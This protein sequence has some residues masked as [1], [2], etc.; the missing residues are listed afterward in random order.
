MQIGVRG[1]GFV[2]LCKRTAG[3]FIAAAV[4]LGCFGVATAQTAL[5]D[6]V[7]KRPRPE[8]DPIGIPLGPEGGFLLFPK[9]EIAGVYID[10]LFK[11]ETGET[12]DEIGLFT[13]SLNIRSDWDLHAL[14]FSA[15]STYAKHRDNSAEDWW[16]YTGK[17]AGRLDVTETGVVS[18]AVSFSRKHENRSSPD[19]PSRTKPTRYTIGE[20]NVI[21]TYNPDVL[22]FR[23]ELSAKQ[24]DYRDNGSVNNDDR[25]R[26]Q[27]GVRGRVGYE[28]VPGSMAFVEVG[29]NKREF[30]E[31]IDIAADGSTKETYDRSSEGYEILF[32]N[33]LDLSGVAFLELAGGY[34]TQDFDASAFSSVEGISFSGALT[35]N[36]TDL[37]TVTGR[38]RRAI[39]ETTAGGASSRLISTFGIDADYEI[40]DNLILD[41]RTSFELSEFEGSTTARDDKTFDVS[42]GGRYLIGPNFFAGAR[43]GFE[44]RNSDLS[45][46]EYTVNT[47]RVFIGAQL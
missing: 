9:L 6:S 45:T 40:L 14:S 10:N 35:W 17:A 29:Y 46:A 4:F 23:V 30:D 3:A 25:D 13:P 15:A 18:S 11:A 7:A 27:Y 31:N 41:A 28:W 39:R 21:G 26:N 19:D 36:P 34:L 22:L 43:Y 5:E 47:I 16:D 1:R 20:I 12:S 37:L 42:I 44:Q 24:F 32:G 38:A 33:T 8:W 2:T